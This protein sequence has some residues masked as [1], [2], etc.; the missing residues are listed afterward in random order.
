VLTTFFIG[1]FLL[2][3][4][5]A[6]VL[7]IGHLRGR[8]SLPRFRFADLWTW[9]G[10]VGRGTYAAVGIIGFAIKHNV[11]RIVAALVF[12]R[13][14]GIFN[15]WI[16]PIEA[17]RISSIASEDAVF[18]VTMLVLSLPF[19][20]VGLGMT[21]RRLRSADLPLWLIFL[22]FVPMLNVVFFLVLSVIAESGTHGKDDA[23]RARAGSPI[24]DSVLGSAA[25]AV[26]LA[27]GVGALLAYVGVETLGVYGWGV[28]VALPFCM[29]LGSVM[30]YSYRRPRLLG[31]CLLVSLT[32]VTL[33][34]A[35]LFAVA[36]EGLICILM[37]IPVALPLALLGG[38][39]GFFI[40]RRRAISAEAPP[41]M[42]LVL[43]LP[44]S[45][46]GFEKWNPP[47]AG[48]I[49]VT[50]TIRIEAPAS[51]VWANLISFPDL[52]ES[53]QWLFQLGVSHPIRATIHGSGVG[54]VRVCV[55]ST[56]TFVERI[57]GWEENRRLAFS[58]VSGADAM[59]EFSPYKIHPRHL[60]GYLVPKRAEFTLI[61]NPDGSTN[62]EG[63]SWYRN[64]MWPATYWRLWSDQ[65]LHDIHNSVFEH[66]KALS[67]QK[68]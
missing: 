45:L 20:W 56:G 4:A 63:K 30:I 48:V 38:L 6:L 22:F 65:I 43:M 15:Y 35:V 33:A 25:I 16:P 62:L 67:E 52:P 40:Q 11:D 41:V 34:A 29:G 14:Y 42:L 53:N 32:T 64:S 46:M 55:F 17:L 57:D 39:A 59:Q 1:F 68:G 66:I 47:E 2:I 28:F 26:A 21:L 50:T 44:L 58:V 24:P 36:V 10:S 7:A 8:R 31:R 18:L 19:I 23:I 51:A 5:V 13:S 9:R 61:S 49:T 27:G 60:D 12:H 54:A 37:A 3:T